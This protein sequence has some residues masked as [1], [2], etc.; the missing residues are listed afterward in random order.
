MIRSCSRGAALLDFVQE[1]DY[2]RVTIYHNG[3]GTVPFDFVWPFGASFLPGVKTI[4]IEPGMVN[5]LQGFEHAITAVGATLI[6]DDNFLTSLSGLPTATDLVVSADNNEIT[7]LAGLSADSKWKSLSLKNNGLTSLSGIYKL[8]NTLKTLDV[9]E[10]QLTALKGIRFVPFLET[11][12][13]SNNEITSLEYFSANKKLKFLS[14]GENNIIS[15]EGIQVLEGTLK[16]LDVSR[17]GLLTDFSL[18]PTSV[19]TL[20]AGATKLA[21]G[22]LANLPNLKHLY[23]SKVAGFNLIE[24]PLFNGL[25]RLHANKN[26]ITSLSHLSNPG[27]E[28]LEELYLNNNKIDD[29]EPISSILP[30]LKQLQVADNRLQS[31]DVLVDQWG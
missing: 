14:V 28:G 10:N 21:V 12:D 11:L 24:L 31:L 18:V 20:F 1:Y 6:V 22:Q 25:T 5:S 16:T 9:R 27:F 2:N 30:T 4:T 23:V 29:L 15:L 26:K 3:F 13:V 8:R 17:N 19:E 7:S